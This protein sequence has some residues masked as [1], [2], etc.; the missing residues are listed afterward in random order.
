[1]SSYCGCC[2]ASALEESRV[3]QGIENS[4]CSRC[5]GVSSTTWILLINPN[6]TYQTIPALPNIPSQ[7]IIGLPLYIRHK[8]PINIMIMVE[9][10]IHPDPLEVVLGATLEVGQHPTKTNT[11]M[12]GVAG[13][14]GTLQD[15]T[16]T[17]SILPERPC[18][19]RGTRG[20]GRKK[21][22]ERQLSTGLFNLAGISF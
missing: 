7:S 2:L 17:T 4:R 15:S 18:R 21:K 14:E 22:K 19:R 3:C 9:I 11:N 5:S 13:L 8:N 10:T 1:M 16:S 12:G 20:G 6:P